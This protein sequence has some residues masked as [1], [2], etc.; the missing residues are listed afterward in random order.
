MAINNLHLVYTKKYNKCS[1]K[2]KCEKAEWKLPIFLVLWKSN[3]QS[4]QHKEE[5]AIF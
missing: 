1:H 4:H 3:E 2:Q 5:V